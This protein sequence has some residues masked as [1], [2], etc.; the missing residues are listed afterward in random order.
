MPPFS[1]LLR[2]NGELMPVEVADLL[3]AVQGLQ[4]GTSAG[5]DVVLQRIPSGDYELWPYRT[6]QE[7]DDLLAAGAGYAAPIRVTVRRGENKIAVKFD[8]R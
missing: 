8:P 6:E 5:S 2:F 4:L 1:L 7:L 3:E